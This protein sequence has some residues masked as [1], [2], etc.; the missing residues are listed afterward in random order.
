ML[1]FTVSTSVLTPEHCPC[2]HTDP[3]EATVH[4]SEHHFFCLSVGFAF[5]RTV[6]LEGQLCPRWCRSAMQTM[7][8]AFAGFNPFDPS[9]GAACVIHLHLIQGLASQE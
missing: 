6:I 7:A 1:S 3:R 8:A 9:L 5:P 2:P 4:F